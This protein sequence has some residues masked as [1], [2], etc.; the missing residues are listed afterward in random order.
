MKKII[1]KSY[2]KTLHFDEF[3]ILF[4]GKNHQSDV[5]VGSFLFEND[6]EDIFQY[7]YSIITLS[8]AHLFLTQKISY[9]EMLVIVIF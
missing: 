6:N 2:Y 7:F 1:I 4:I 5:V 8:T 9:L 3:P